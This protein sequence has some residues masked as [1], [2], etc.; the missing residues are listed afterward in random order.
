MILSKLPRKL[1][2]LTAA[3]CLSTAAI[4]D[5]HGGGHE[6]SITMIDS[7]DFGID[8]S[9]IQSIR[10]QMQAAVDGDF[11]SGN[12]ILVGNSEGVGVL[13]TVD[14]QGP[15]QTTEMNDQ[16]LFRIYSMTSLSSV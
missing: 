8:Q 7:S 10:E 4:A 6:S 5:H 1:L 9:E 14:T 11:V 12:I 3:V 2:C 15:N 13:E 16:T